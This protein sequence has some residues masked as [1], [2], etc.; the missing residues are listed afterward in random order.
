MTNTFLHAPTA[1]LEVQ[2]FCAQTLRV[3]V[4]R[5]FEELPAG[6]WLASSP[7][8]RHV[9]ATVGTPSAL[10]L[11]PT[12]PVSSDAAASLRDSLVAAL[13]RFS[14]GPSSVR[15]ALCLALAALSAHTPPQQWGHPDGALG[16][17]TARLGGEPKERALPCLLQLLVVLP[18]EAGSPRPAVRPE[19]RRAYAAE[20]LAAAPGA[21][22]LLAQLYGARKEVSAAEEVEVAALE[23][24]ASW[25]WLA[26]NS[27]HAQGAGSGP[28]ALAAWQ[29]PASSGRRYPPGCEPAA[30][31]SH[32][33]TAASLAGLASP[34]TFDA[35]VEAVV[36]LIRA[37]AP[38]APRWG[39]DAADAGGFAPVP[40]P[41]LMDPANAP[42][43]NVVI[44]AVM[45]LCF[46]FQGADDDMAKGYARLFTEVGEG[47]L[48]LVAS[49]TP[50][51][52]ALTDALLAVAGHS[53]DD[54]ASVSY[55]FWWRLASR[56]LDAPGP[57]EGEQECARR[58][59]VFAPAFTHFVRDAAQRVRYPEDFGNWRREARVAFRKDRS[60]VGDALLQAA[61]VLGGDAALHILA[62]PLAALAAVAAAAPAVHEFDWRTAEAALYCC[63]SVAKA[64]PPT[65]S[66]L[67]AQL[68]GALHTLP[69][70]AELQYTACMMAGAYAD[71]IAAATASGNPH[72]QGLLTNVLTLL[73]SALSAGGDAP[74]AAAHALRSLCDA[75]A[76]QLV[77]L[78]AQL[79]DVYGRI[80]AADSDVAAPNGGV[81]APPT[82]GLAPNDIVDITSGLAHL[83]GA[84]PSPEQQRAA[85]DAILAP[86]M[87]VLDVM[88]AQHNGAGAMGL[89]TP[90][91]ALLS[92]QFDRISAA[93]RYC[94]CPD[95]A[96]GIL[97][98]RLWPLI[99][100]AW[101]S[102][103]DEGAC[104]RVCR[105]LKYAL[106][107]GGAPRCSSI[108][109]PAAD[110]LRQLFHARRHACL[111]FAAS[112]LVREFAGDA[113]AVPHLT[114]LL[115]S[116]FADVAASLPSLAAFQA[117]PDVVD[118]AFLLA[119]KALKVMPGSVFDPPTLHAL[120][121]LAATG[122][123]VQHREACQ[124]LLLFTGR[125][126]RCRQG[127]QVMALSQVLLHVGPAL[128]QALLT[129]A[130]VALPPARISDVADALH[131][132][133]LLAQGTALAWVMA[134]LSR[135]N[136][137]AA[138]QHDVA[139]L[140]RVCTAAATPASPD[141]CP[142]VRALGDALDELA[143][144]TRRNRRAYEAAD[145]ALRGKQ[146]LPPPPPM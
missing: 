55:T 126:L 32:A 63:R 138:P 59:G 108:L 141:A 116:L 106:R 79:L 123:C 17:L 66:A 60:T 36:E 84:L 38:P 98:T 65:D 100:A 124:S 33:M 142:S 128:T 113:G 81:Q 145:A 125:L 53:D 19:R 139:A 104:D 74:G 132:L 80:M 134:T 89:Q 121:T 48:E 2:L 56:L 117:A 31:A 34:Q 35:A 107:T 82:L 72:A 51:A 49:A 111:L 62:E 103:P 61:R 78:M 15:T 97:C 119:D 1:A 41:V 68:L 118:D 27:P 140:A 86:P 85:L 122:A 10:R 29:Q 95:A 23:A 91:P 133:L 136:E 45:A 76:P 94:G 115:A 120:L 20:L 7:R 109:A 64:C 26:C 11:T 87:A 75:A 92:R 70:V 146:Q 52:A 37:A 14:G 144:V 9:P 143:Q 88:L 3:K 47:F 73:T 129:A 105:T 22:A 30:L 25:V 83:V 114:A 40:P 102:C 39:D 44:P 42:L 24:Y 137:T 71:W 50:E 135:L 8:G 43:V 16:A 67:L 13:L 110:L 57:G 46:E 21:L 90:P 54:V 96:A 93:I 112:E 58:R 12:P 18:Q 69:T 5:D 130:L 28:D 99:A 77:P 131:A 101:A 6:A 4:E 127:D